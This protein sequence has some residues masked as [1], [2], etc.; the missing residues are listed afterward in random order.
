MRVLEREGH[1]GSRR[2]PKGADSTSGSDGDMEAFAPYDRTVLA[3]IAH[4][5][6]QQGTAQRFLE[7]MSRPARFLD[8][9]ARRVPA[10]HR[11]GAR[12]GEAVERVAERLTEAAAGHGD[13]ATTRDWFWRQGVAVHDWD[14]IATLPLADRD[15][16]STAVPKWWVYGAAEGG[17]MGLVQGLADVAVLPWV[18]MVAVDATATIWM[19]AREATM[20]AAC[21]GFDPA[22][23]EL[24]A[25]LMAAMLPPEDWDLT[26]Y[27]GMKALLSHPRV[28]Q[29]ALTDLWTR[30][31]TAMI[32]DKEAT[33]WLPL[34]GAVI[35]AAL[36]GA[37]LYGVRDSARDYFRL[38]DLAH[39]YGADPVI[40][41]LDGLAP[42]A[43]PPLAD[44]S[45]LVSPG[46][47]P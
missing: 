7:Q 12:I 32:T 23:P 22:R 24:R 35:N 19:G 42:P 6:R 27:L 41:A 18:G 38:L 36:N 3:E 14:Q 13:F 44:V 30:R 29:R 9:L 40:N 2:S 17:A 47:E 28:A 43:H 20:Q 37:Y 10:V 34:A 39:R 8:R 1:D 33:V 15:R 26:R 11:A 46:V 16:L 4:H 45:R 21:Y 31:M 5:R 25:H